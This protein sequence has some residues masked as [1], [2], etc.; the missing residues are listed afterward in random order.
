M[1]ARVEMVVKVKQHTAHGGE[2]GWSTSTRTSIT[3][4]SRDLRIN[5][6]NGHRL[7][8]FHSPQEPQSP[9]AAARS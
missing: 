7:S 9:P 3:S 8:F 5:V 1:G 4:I 2:L 6:V